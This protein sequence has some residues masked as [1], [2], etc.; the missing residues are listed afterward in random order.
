M[1]SRS[2]S[3]GTMTASGTTQA[4]GLKRS[5][6]AE[7]VPALGSPRFL[8]RHARPD[9]RQAGPAGEISDALVDRPPRAL[10]TVGRHAEVA[11]IDAQAHFP[12]SP[13]AAARGRAADDAESQPFHD[14]GDQL[15]VAMFADQDVHLGPVPVVGGKERDL[16]EER[17]DIAL[18]GGAGHFGIDDWVLIAKMIFQCASE[19]PDQ[20]GPG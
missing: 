10:G 16:V 6:H 17:V 20:G 9:D 1:V 4:A 7:P 12:E 8:E 18:A 5:R 2:A 15:A 19:L 3:W 14:L 13:S 11:L